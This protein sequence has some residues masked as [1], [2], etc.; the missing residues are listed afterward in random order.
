MDFFKKRMAEPSTWAGLAAVLEAAKLIF[1]QFA[2]LI[3]GIQAAAGGVAIIARET[4]G[5]GGL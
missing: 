4:G 1:P 3:V 5:G 2:P